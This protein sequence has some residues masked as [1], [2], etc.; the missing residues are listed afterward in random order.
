MGGTL[1]HQKVTMLWK[2]SL[3]MF[4]Y[5]GGCFS[6]FKTRSFSKQNKVH[7]RVQGTGSFR[8]EHL[9]LYCPSACH[10][11]SSKVV[12]GL[13]SKAKL[14]PPN[15]STPTTWYHLSKKQP[16]QAGKVNSIARTITGTSLIRIYCSCFDLW[17]LGQCL[18]WC[19][20]LIGNW[21]ISRFQLVYSLWNN[22]LI[23]IE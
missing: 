19:K 14:P 1:E 11:N 6:P 16:G 15:S 12:F 9:R 21:S 17:L 7:Q 4:P 5:F 13:V 8:V 18:C 2:N 20:L 23:G 3:W 22:W 10:P